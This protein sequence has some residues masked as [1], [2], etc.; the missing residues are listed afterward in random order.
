MAVVCIIKGSVLK[1]ANP[2]REAPGQPPRKGYFGEMPFPEGGNCTSYEF[3]PNDPCPG[4]G[5]A[6]PGLL[7]LI[8]H[9]LI[10]P[11]LRKVSQCPRTKFCSLPCTKTGN[12]EG[13]FGRS[14]SLLSLLCV[15]LPLVSLPQGEDT[16]ADSDLESQLSMAMFYL[17]LSILVFL[18]FY[19][20]K[21]IHPVVISASV[22]CTHLY[23][24]VRPVP[25]CDF[26]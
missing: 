5:T 18:L 22:L 15:L 16:A 1:K 3:P 8:E 20:L 9:E 24:C 4:I 19:C 10:L 25:C 2:R 7:F 17:Q 14:F 21:H 23:Q 6:S 12:G 11:A 13:R 26:L